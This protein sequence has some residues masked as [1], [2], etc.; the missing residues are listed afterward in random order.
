MSK[1]H[2]ATILRRSMDGD[3][4]ILAI[5]RAHGTAAAGLRE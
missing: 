3:I 5:A 1:D 2:V 4:R